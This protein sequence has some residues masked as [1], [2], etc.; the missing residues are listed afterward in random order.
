V[1]SS[2]PPTADHFG[3]L[4]RLLDLEAKAEQEEARR[5][6]QAEEGSPL[7]D[8]ATLMRLALRDAEF[9]LGGRLL[10]TLARKTPGELLPPSR[11]GPGSPVVL[12]Q[13]GVNRRVPSYRGVVYDRDAGTVGVAID[14]PDDELPDDA[15]WRIDLSPDEVSRLRQQDALR[16][17]AAAAGDRLAELRAVLLGERQ[18]EFAANPGREAG[19]EEAIDAAASHPDSGEPGPPLNPPQREA[20]EF[21][22]A[23]KDVAIIHGPPGTGKTTTVVEVIRRAGRG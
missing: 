8:G 5:R 10:L 19:G 6:A 2:V 16:R 18:P 11:L 13:T 9:G 14:P 4:S 20:V 17:A 21:A 3:N 15:T 12:S 1:L 7:G 22:L 23:A